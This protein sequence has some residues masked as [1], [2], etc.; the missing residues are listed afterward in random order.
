LVMSDV[1]FHFVQHQLS[2]TFIQI[3]KIQSHTSLPFNINVLILVGVTDPIESSGSRL[4]QQAD[5][6]DFYL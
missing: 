1:I 3:F 6:R 2:C 5:A 4:R